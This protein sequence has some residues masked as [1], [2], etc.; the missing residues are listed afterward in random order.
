MH[1]ELRA[2]QAEGLTVSAQTQRYYVLNGGVFQLRL[3]RFCVGSTEKIALTSYDIVIP[4]TYSIFIPL[5]N[6]RG[7]EVAQRGERCKKNL[8]LQILR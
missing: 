2:Q 5:T 4:G 3:V 8:S 7:L 1:A 6:L